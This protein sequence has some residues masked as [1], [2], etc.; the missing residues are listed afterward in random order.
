MFTVV[1]VK[2]GDLADGVEPWHRDQVMRD[3]RKGAIKVLITTAAALSDAP[4]RRQPGDT[5][6]GSRR[7]TTP[8][9]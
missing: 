6:L 8:D 3:F 1:G 9:S 4:T 7:P 5:H 2:S